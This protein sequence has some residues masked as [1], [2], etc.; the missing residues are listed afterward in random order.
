MNNLAGKKKTRIR[1]GGLL[2]V[3]IFAVCPAHTSWAL[4]QGQEVVSGTASFDQTDASTLNITASDKSIIQYNSFSIGANEKVN[5]IMPSLDSFL[6]NRVVGG[7]SSQILGQLYANGNLILI[8]QNGINF[9][10][11]AQV[12]VGGLMA[13][14]HDITN[15]NFLNGQYIFAGTGI[16]PN[17]FISNEGSIKT[18]DGGFAVLAADAIKNTG[19]IEAPVGTV[20]LAAGKFIKIDLYADG[21]VSVAI[22]EPTAQNIY[23]ANGNKLETQLENS[24]TLSGAKVEL[25]AQSVAQ[26]FQSAINQE[27]IIRANEVKVGQDGVVEITASGLIESSGEIEAKEIT[28]KSEQDIKV[29]GSYG[30]VGGSTVFEA[31]RDLTTTGPI[32]TQG[33]T[34]FKAVNNINVNFN[35]TTD[36]GNLTF[37][38]DSDKD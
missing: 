10:Q 35:V 27:G 5:F 34:T 2:L 20:S 23:D 28:V 36:S 8:N 6:L 24:G 25:N 38:A 18:R 37:I 1:V 29:Q 11:N 32:S 12:N 16:N 21:L 9:G 14:T 4:P 30:S 19:T 22:D 33:T 17:S 13:S 31:G 26:I 3:M 7:G 15:Q